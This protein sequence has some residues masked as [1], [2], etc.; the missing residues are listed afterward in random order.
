[1]D[2]RTGQDKF[3]GALLGTA[4]GDIL[5]A[6][7]EGCPRELIKTRHGQV[8]DFQQSERGFGLYTDDTEMALALA[9]AIVQ[10][11]A[12]KAESCAKM[13]VEYYNSWRGYGAGAHAVIFALKNGTGYK[14]TGSMVFKNGSFANGGAMRIAPVGLF[15]SNKSD[16]E[17]KKAVYEA[18][19]CTH[20]HP[21]AIDGA[22]IQAKAV[23]YFAI[24]DKPDDID[25]QK[26]LKTL[27]GLCDTEI[28]KEKLGYV[29]EVLVKSIPDD[30]AVNCLGNGLRASEAVPCA[31]LAGLRYYA[32]PEEAVIESVNFGGDTDTIGA[33]TGAQMGALH[34]KDWLPARW[35]DNIEN[36]KYGRDYIIKLG[37]ELAGVV[38]NS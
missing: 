35:F 21:E 23:A 29:A 30:T 5:G 33:M 9:H 2:L 6:A 28:M 15:C 1:M 4:V 18:I 37:T 20:I 13:Y 26:L 10:E 8:R 24:T 22:R 27:T 16:D 36:G 12:V 25:V 3:I 34:G 38:G 11:K 7:V 17:L 19:C 31:L 32:N 14:E